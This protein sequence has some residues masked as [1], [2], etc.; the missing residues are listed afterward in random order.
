[1]KAAARV[2][3]EQSLE[4]A[5]ARLEGLLPNAG[6]VADSLAA[7]LGVSTAG[8][9]PGEA[10]LAVRRFLETLAADRP[11]LVV[12]DDIHWAEPTLLDLIE[13]VVDAS[14]VVPLVIVCVARPELLEARPTWQA[15]QSNAESLKLEPLAAAESTVLIGKTAGR[16][17][18]G[19]AGCRADRSSRRGKPTLHR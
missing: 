18:D 6:A 12:L 11:L 2:D 10:Q 17:Q 13:Y 1:M 14:R 15:R 7:A 5:L 9:S 4:V 8:S 19:R 3:E 16:E